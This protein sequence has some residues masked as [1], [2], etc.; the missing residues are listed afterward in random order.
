MRPCTALVAALLAILPAAAQERPVFD[1]PRV[2]GVTIDGD[3]ADW[4]EGGLRVRIMTS[5][6]GELAEPADFDPQFRL[7]WNADG[8]LVALNVRD[9]D[10]VE[11]PDLD[12]LWTADSAEVFVSTGVGQGQRYQV[13]VAPGLDPRFGAM[14]YKIYDYRLQQLPPIAVRL[15]DRT[16]KDGY[17]LEVLLPWANIGMAP[18]PGREL[19]FQIYVNDV[20][21][22]DQRLGLKWYPEG[23]THMRV[24]AMHRIRLAEQ[25][26]QAIVAVAAV[27]V[28]GAGNAR[29]LL[30][31]AVPELAGRRV[32]VISQGRALGEARLEP[33]GG[34]AVAVVPVPLRAVAHGLELRVEGL[35]ALPITLPRIA[36]PVAPVQLPPPR[37]TVQLTDQALALQQERLKDS[38]LRRED[39]V[40]AG[41]TWFAAKD[42]LVMIDAPNRTMH[43]FP[44][45]AAFGL[46]SVAEFAFGKQK[47]WLATDVGLLAWDREG[48][49]LSRFAPDDRYLAAPAA[50]VSL[51]AD[52]SV[53]V[54][55][56]PP[57]RPART[58]SYDPVKDAWREE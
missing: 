33:R 1:V 28:P 55:L 36:A 40:A 27:G 35:P 14:R 39:P 49:Y 25:P 24:G 5:E 10:F 52:G 17:S 3:L 41:C 9:D 4:G 15:A 51:A 19:G 58:F 29:G 21:G 18:E 30:I 53:R 50:S 23:N 57:G 54:K 11:G 45:L 2:E 48:C 38:P 8:L 32:E 13:A 7:G 12:N 6:T 34:R 42:G 26:G 16:R 20:D 43:T 22:R 47:V 44:E 56:E 31:H 46:H 37:G